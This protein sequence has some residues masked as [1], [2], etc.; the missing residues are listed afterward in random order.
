MELAK[1]LIASIGA[2][3]ESFAPSELAFLALTSKVE[4]PLLDRVS[5]QL[6][7]VLSLEG[8]AVARECPVG[9]GVRADVA[10]LR[11]GELQVA[12]EA[13]AM[14]T[15]DCTRR[16]GLDRQY[17]DL[18]DADL[19]RYGALTVGGLKVY[20]LLLGTHLLSAPPRTLKRVIK[21]SNMIGQAFKAHTS[22]E[23][24]RAVAEKNLAAFVRPEVR[25]AGGAIK[26]GTAFELEVEVMWWLY[27][28]FGGNE[29]WEI[30]RS[31]AAQP[32]HAA[33]R[34][35]VSRAPPGRFVPFGRSGT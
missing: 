22:A 10:V 8:F 32:A 27:G 3:G 7:R 1:R 18:L 12:L 26:A 25:I 19:R 11:N 30:L 6:H 24:I 33:D 17:P 9:G 16:G 31:G 35:A 2:A 28:P 5:Y 23:E 21:Y 15:A 14:Y 34:P 4:R 29:G 20:S 13:K